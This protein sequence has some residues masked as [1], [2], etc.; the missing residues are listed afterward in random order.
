MARHHSRPRR[1]FAV[2]CLALCVAAAAA[3]AALA[4]YPRL[5]GARISEAS[6]SNDR[7][8]ISCTFHKT[9]SFFAQIYLNPSNADPASP[10]RIRWVRT[11][12]LGEHHAGHGHVSFLLGTLA[13]GKY[14]IVLLP[15]HA[16]SQKPWLST[17]GVGSATGATWLLLTVKVVVV[18]LHQP[19]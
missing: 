15:T 6:I 8:T 11:I 19:A 2:F 18:G 3:S 5:R 9:H 12:P 7:V 17:P 16:V 4:D 14:G 13:P 10:S 1:L